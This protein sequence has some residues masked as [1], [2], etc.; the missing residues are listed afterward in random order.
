MSTLKTLTRSEV[1]TEFLKTKFT[2]SKRFG[3]E[4]CDAFVSGLETL[5]EK[6]AEYKMKHIIIGMPHRGRLNVLE[7]VLEKSA[8]SI[9]AEF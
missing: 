7:T 3:A 5:A 4:G 8:E 2:T 6:A 9:L 1:L